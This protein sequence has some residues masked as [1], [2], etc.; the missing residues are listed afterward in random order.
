MVQRKLPKKQ[1]KR[2]A[3]IV[4]TVCTLNEE[5]QS[6]LHEKLKEVLESERV[7]VKFS[8]NP[9]LLGGM[10][11]QINSRLVDLSVVGQ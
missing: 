6:R 11:L 3:V 5:Q 9:K 1:N 2:Y 7:V 4:E 8:I 10:T